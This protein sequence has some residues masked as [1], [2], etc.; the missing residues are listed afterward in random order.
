MD[1]LQYKRRI[2]TDFAVERMPLLLLVTPTNMLL[3]ISRNKGHFDFLFLGEIR[4]SN[5]VILCL[6]TFT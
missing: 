4:D 5:V 6:I 3:N 2:N 1:L